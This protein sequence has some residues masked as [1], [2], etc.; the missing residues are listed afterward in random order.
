MNINLHNY[1]EFLLLYADNEL[2]PQDRI[3]VEQF[4]QDNPE[5][6]EEF[7]MIN[8][9]IIEPDETFQ[10]L[11]KSFLMKSAEVELIHEQN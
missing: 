4:I 3:L 1:E 10:I 5:L 11:D 6:E 7:D 2:S 8:S 9:T